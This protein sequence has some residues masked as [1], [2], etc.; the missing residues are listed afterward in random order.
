MR[1]ISTQID[2]DATPAQVWA[3]LV[4]FSRYPEWNPFI[5]EAS[6]QARVGEILTLRMF[7]ANGRPRTFTPQVLVAEAGVELRW[8][9]RFVLP[10]VF[11]GEHRFVLTPHDDGTRLVQ[12]EKFTGLLVPF[13][14]KMIESTAESF[15][16]LNTALKNQMET[17]R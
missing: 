1:Q 13:L 7:P 3:V 12:S 16:L 10:G 14:G 4:D 8:L 11:N 9:G 2:I 5:R 17:G 15:Q 6:G